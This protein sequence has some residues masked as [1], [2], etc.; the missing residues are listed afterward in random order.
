MVFLL[1]RSNCMKKESFLILGA[2]LI[3]GAV[4][5]LILTKP[6]MKHERGMDS[7]DMRKHK[8]QQSV[9][10]TNMVMGMDHALTELEKLEGAQLDLAFLA[11]MIP[12]H[13]GAV[14]MAEE[15]LERGAH[16]ELKQLATDII[17]AQKKEI[18]QME[19]WKA[20]WS[21]ETAS[22]SGAQAR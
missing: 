4:V 16:P 8:V 1:K 9:A 10:K 22:P 19:A 21:Q 5:T 12:H 15:V 2:G 18:T 6:F 14:E 13:E 20:E 7:D 11:M 17:T 3:V